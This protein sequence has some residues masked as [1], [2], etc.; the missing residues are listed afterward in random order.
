VQNVSG[1]CKSTHDKKMAEVKNEINWECFF[2]NYFALN[3]TTISKSEYEQGL[4]INYEFNDI[5]VFCDLDLNRQK[6]KKLEFGR[7]V[8][9]SRNE[10]ESNWIKGVF[11]NDEPYNLIF[12][13]TSWFSED[14]LQYEANF[15]ERNKIVVSNFLKTPYY[16]GWTE[17]EFWI[18]DC[19]YKIIASTKGVQNSITLMDIGEQDI[20]ML[21]DKF[22]QWLR[23]KIYDSFWNKKRRKIKNIIVEPM[24]AR[25]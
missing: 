20:P 16:D 18:K 8:F 21:T 14:G 1:H 6:L 7:M 19:C 12:L 11:I 23:V 3:E 10:K 24:K 17:D 25:K 5:Y 13:Q 15:N 9:D 2:D 22:D 4:T